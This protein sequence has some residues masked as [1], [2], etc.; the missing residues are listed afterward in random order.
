MAPEYTDVAAQLIEIIR[1][2]IHEDGGLSLSDDDEREVAEIIAEAII[3]A[4]WPHD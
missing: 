2:S 4:G 3:S 1:R